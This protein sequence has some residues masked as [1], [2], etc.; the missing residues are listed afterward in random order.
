MAQVTISRFPTLKRVTWE[1]PS[2]TPQA[3][4][5]RGWVAVKRTL[6][7]DIRPLNYKAFYP[8]PSLAFVMPGS[9]VRVTQAAPSLQSHSEQDQTPGMGQSALNP[10]LSSF[11]SQGRT[12]SWIPSTAGFATSC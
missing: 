5:G 11:P 4:L 10:V 1:T 2:P 8:R 12:G 7:T 9:G 3:R 6:K